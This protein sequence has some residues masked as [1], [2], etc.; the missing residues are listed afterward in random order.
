M[1]YNSIQR[2][3][4]VGQRSGHPWARRSRA[5]L[6]SSSTSLIMQ[7]VSQPYI[8]ILYLSL[9]MSCFLSVVIRHLKIG[10][11]DHSAT[12]WPSRPGVNRRGGWPGPGAPLHAHHS[13]VR[14]QPRARTPLHVHAHA[15][16]T[17]HACILASMESAAAAKGAAAAKAQG[18]GCRQ[19]W[20]WAKFT[21]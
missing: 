17:L 21:L 12:R 2:R 5:R 18:C 7:T 15:V 3:R 4:V 10:C 1:R 13:R 14:I 9:L 8:R 6:D 20:C 11:R 19:G 16:C